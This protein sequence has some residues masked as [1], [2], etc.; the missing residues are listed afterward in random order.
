MIRLNRIVLG[1]AL[2]A[3]LAFSTARAAEPDKLLPAESDTVVQVNLKQIIG[4]DI[5]KKYALEQLKQT[6]EGEDAKKLLTEIGL[7]PLKDIEKVV[8][9]AH[10]KGKDDTKYLMV[11]HGTFDPDKLYKAAEAQSKKDADRF[12]MIKEE[13][14]VIFKYQPANGELP[15]Y[16]TVINDRTVVAGSNKKMIHAAIKAAAADKKSAIKPELA[17]L[18]KK[19][20]EKSSFYAVSIVKGK[21]TDVNLP[22]GGNIPVDLSGIQKLLPD[23]ESMAV[24]VKVGADVNVEV[25]LGMKSDDSAGDMRNALDEI[26]KQLKPLAQLAAAAEPRAKPLGDI[27]ATIKTSAKNK[28]VIISGKV[29]G[30]N[31]GRMVKP[32]ADGDGR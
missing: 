25:T 8:V 23:T 24:A 7:D 1:S 3:G 29:T 27:L 4:T 10:V 6:L 12:A 14:S 18:V 26:F 20:D 28:D 2:F 13:N 15:V 22:G 31:I 5:V 16:G 21:F 17:E 30:A 11:V 9:G 19:M 32:D